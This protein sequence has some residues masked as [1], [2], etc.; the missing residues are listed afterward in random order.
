MDNRGLH[1]NNAKLYQ[2]LVLFL[3]FMKGADM[4]R[5]AHTLIGIKIH[6][7]DGDMGHVDDFYFDDE[8]WTVRYMIVRTGAWFLGKQVMLSPS[9][10]RDLG[11]EEGALYVD[12]TQDQLKNS[13]DLDL[14]KPVTREQEMELAKYYR[15]P[16]YWP[17]VPGR[18]FN[19]PISNL[20]T[21]STGMLNPDISS[22]DIPN[23]DLLNREV[24]N[25]AETKTEAEVRRAAQAGGLRHLRGVKEVTGYH[26]TAT[27]G[28]IGH[29]EDFF[30]DEESWQIH[31]LLVDTGNWLPGRKVLISPNWITGISWAD[32][33]VIVKVTR[34]QVKDSPEYDP[35][36]SIDRHYENSLY[37]YYG[38]PRDLRR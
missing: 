18:V 3:L 31:Y 15:W 24:S 21:A 7:L 16:T 23:P 6:A 27:D 10:I 25:T 8:D 4:L 22:T 12:L 30:I 33:E 19:T 11:W 34:E 17:V 2:S 20:G 9:V 32:S 13:P 5:K 14:E 35:R 36:G 28:E 38:F 29:V 37:G 26:I 1:P